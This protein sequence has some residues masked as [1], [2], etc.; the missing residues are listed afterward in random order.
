MRHHRDTFS[1]EERGRGFSEG[2]GENVVVDVMECSRATARESALRALSGPTPPQGVYCANDVLAFGVIEAAVQLGFRIPEDL[3]VVGFDD[4]DMAASP[5]F[6]L[7]TLR[8]EPFDISG[9]IV[10]RLAERLKNPGLAV[11]VHRMPAQLVLR[12]ST[13][14]SNR[15]GG[16]TT[17]PNSQQDKS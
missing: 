2:L 10:A 17:L 11:T 7:T 4:V 8:Q 13:P 12:G 16:V 9:W 14:D 15:I 3:M 1:D 6:S 5:F